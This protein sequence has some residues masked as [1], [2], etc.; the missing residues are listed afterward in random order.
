[1]VKLTAIWSDFTTA[2]L[3]VL[4]HPLAEFK[5]RV[6]DDLGA[7]HCIQYLVIY[8]LVDPF[9]LF[10]S[11]LEV[12]SRSFFL[13]L[14]SLLVDQ[15]RS[16]I[17]SCGFVGFNYRNFCIFHWPI[18]ELMDSGY[19]IFSISVVTVCACMFNLF[20]SCCCVNLG[21]CVLLQNLAFII[22]LSDV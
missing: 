8:A 21:I 14:N 1:M 2:L 18:L 17:A 9:Y 11:L 20:I 16:R 13:S 19:L 6:L 22:S 15:V 5:A 3:R 7:V 10:H 12:H 4:L